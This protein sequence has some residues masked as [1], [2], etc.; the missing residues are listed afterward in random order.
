M[1]VFVALQILA[2]VV[3]GLSA[4]S[5]SVLLLPWGG[6]GYRHDDFLMT[7]LDQVDDEDFRIFLLSPLV[8]PFS[9]AGLTE[10]PAV[11]GGPGI[12]VNPCGRRT[13]SSGSIRPSASRSSSRPVRPVLL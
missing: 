3:L 2:L 13:R 8:R 11:P 6:G 1:L 5:L 4:S 10:I 7:R 12:S 9:G